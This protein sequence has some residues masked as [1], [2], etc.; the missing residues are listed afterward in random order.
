MARSGE[1]IVW[2]FFRTVVEEVHG[3]GECL[4]EV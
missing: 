1:V 4:V 3:V 2:I